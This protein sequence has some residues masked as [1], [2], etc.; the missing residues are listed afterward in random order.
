MRWYAL[1]VDYEMSGKDLIDSVRVCSRIA[2]VLGGVPPEGFSYELFLDE[3]GQKISKSKGNGLTVEEWLTYAPPESLALF[4]Y[5]KPRAAKRLYFDV[6]PRTVDE[7]LGLLERFPQEDEARRLENPVWHI[8]DGN[9]P[10]YRGRLSFSVLLNLA[11]VCNTDDPDVLWGFIFR[12]DSDVTPQ[13]APIL[14]A[15]VGYAIAYYRDFVKPAKRYR[16]PDAMERA[17]L[18]DLLATLETLP[19]DAEAETIQYEVYEVG[20][21]HPFSDLRAWFKALY[22]ILFGQEQG[23][24]MGSFITL[25]GKRE[26]AALVR[27]AL[28]GDDPR[29]N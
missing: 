19:D 20:K 9:P 26:S 8:H 25:Y 23:P 2:R 24:R 14:D 12:Y 21:R 10:A 29:Q 22:E 6:I 5:Q 28:A 27:R 18:E 7:Y 1:G 3:K 11:S 17:A 13:N 4:M 16:R 15:L